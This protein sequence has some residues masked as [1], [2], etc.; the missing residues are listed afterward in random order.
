MSLYTRPESIRPTNAPNSLSSS[1]S[2]S[3]E[4]AAGSSFVEYDLTL[5]EGFMGAGCA[6]VLPIYQS[7]T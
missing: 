6:H 4:C 1:S 2:S 7:K 3:N 5:P